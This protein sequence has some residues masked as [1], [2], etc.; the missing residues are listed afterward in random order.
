MNIGPR[1]LT[2]L[3]EILF[4]LDKIEFN[5][6]AAHD[7][8]ERLEKKWLNAKLNNLRESGIV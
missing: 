2:K 5:L 6:D 4:D 8:V 7:C 3:A 1:L